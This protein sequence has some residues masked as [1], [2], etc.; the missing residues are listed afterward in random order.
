MLSKPF[1]MNA[2]TSITHITV[3]GI[4]IFQSVLI[5]WEM[6]KPF[7]NWRGWQS[8]KGYWASQL[9]IQW[10]ENFSHNNCCLVEYP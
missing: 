4:E 10:V 7:L 9:S 1:F 3:G 2:V 6:C 5:V 8:I